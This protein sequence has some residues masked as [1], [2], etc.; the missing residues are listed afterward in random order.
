LPEVIDRPYPRV[1][2][3]SLRSGFQ[4]DR[5]HNAFLFQPF[6]QKDAPLFPPYPL[7]KDLHG[8]GGLGTLESRH[9]IVRGPNETRLN[10]DLGRGG[11]EEIADFPDRREKIPSGPFRELDVGRRQQGVVV[12][13]LEERFRFGGQLFRGM[14]DV[15]NV[16]DRDPIPE[17]DDHPRSGIDFFG[18]SVSEGSP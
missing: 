8:Y 12:D 18:R 9:L 7:E 10:Y 1:G 11:K 5:P 16:P 13:D 4:T 3:G 17:I 6:F 2:A 15:Q 14:G